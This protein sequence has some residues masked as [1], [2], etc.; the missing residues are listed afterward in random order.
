MLTFCKVGVFIPEKI[1]T[2]SSDIS[3]VVKDPKEN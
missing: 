2:F 3:D 1:D